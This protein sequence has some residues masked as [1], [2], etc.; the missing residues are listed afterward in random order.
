M[1]MLITRLAFGAAALAVFIT[2]G[3]AEIRYNDKTV[4]AP[5]GAILVPLRGQDI[6]KTIAQAKGNHFI[7]PV[8]LWRTK[9]GIWLRNGMTLIGLRTE[10]Y[11]HQFSDS[12]AIRDAAYW[13]HGCKQRHDFNGPV[14]INSDDDLFEC[15]KRQPAYTLTYPLFAVMRWTSER[16]FPS[17]DPSRETVIDGRGSQCVICFSNGTENV[18]IDSLT[19][20]GG[21]VGLGYGKRGAV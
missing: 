14:R 1:M 17:T 21:R 4:V 8:G 16:A 10:G 3:A 5:S 13:V 18:R 7:I 20:T 12:L 15:K 11:K 6:G 2:A 9:S 19:I